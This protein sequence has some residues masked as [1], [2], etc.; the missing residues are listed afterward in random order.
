MNNIYRLL[1]LSV[2]INGLLSCVTSKQKSERAVKIQQQGQSRANRTV[3]RVGQQSQDAVKEGRISGSANQAIQD[4]LRT[5]QDSIRRDSLVLIAAAEELRTAGQ[6]GSKPTDAAIAEAQFAVTRSTKR[7]RAF[8]QKTAVIVDFLNSETFSKSEMNTLFA[9][10]EYRLAPQ[11]MRQGRQLFGPTVEKL[12][13]FSEKYRGAF[14]SMQG[15]IIVT[16]YSDATPVEAGSRL[17]SDLTQRL[18][19]DE[20]MAAPTSAD[21]NRKLSELRAEAVKDLIETIVQDKMATGK[22]LTVTVKRLGRG[23][24]IPP[25]LP[26]NVV[27]DDRRRRIVTFYWVVLPIL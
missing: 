15:E 12:F 20:Q 25:F 8:E 23:E 5:Q 18:S 21:L 3:G 7:L 2:L 9:T 17:Y 19:R 16:G 4:Y 24:E 11:Q 13:T 1:L 22:F 14:Q 6:R 26:Q 10:G 27:R